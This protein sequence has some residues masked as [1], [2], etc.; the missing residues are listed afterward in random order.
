[1][2]I[3]ILQDQLRSGGTERHSLLLAREFAAAGHAASLLTFRPGGRLAG[4][5]QV[6][7]G[8]IDG[9]SHRC[10]QPFDTGL[11]WFAPGLGRAVGE[12]NP[13]IVLCMGK[14][15]NA[16]AGRLQDR[17]RREERATAVVAT[18]RSGYRLPGY[19]LRSVRR[20]PLL[21]TNSHQAADL[22]VAQY[23]LARE[24]IA[25][26][27]NALVFAGAEPGPGAVPPP[28]DARPHPLSPRPSPS[29]PTQH[30]A[31][32]P[33]SVSLSVTPA[34]DDRSESK[35][36][37]IL[38]EQLGAGPATQVMLSV[39][40]FRP[41]KNQ[42]ALIEA[43]AGLPAELDWQLW[44]AGEGPTRRECERLAQRL[45]AG[46]RVRFL[47]FTGDPAPLYRAADVA[48][49]ASREESLS[50]FLIEAQAHGLPVVAAEAL[51]NR[52]CVVPGETGW[53][54]PQDDPAAFR[55]ALLPLL[56][57]P[58]EARA[59]LAAEASAFARAAFDPERQVR[60]YLECFRELMK[61][62]RSLSG[63]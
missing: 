56:T 2:K 40:M 37:R 10:L 47:G 30:S 52:E 35:K 49:H 19:Y 59:A 61:A 21:I 43:A 17:A 34:M 31:S 9:V 23:G 24:R 26:I 58:A 60:A 15:A 13:D 46:G 63:A 57:A 48:V 53:I 29:S 5:A 44:C 4:A 16:Y 11:D 51:G 62:P 50:N 1:M 12:A 22:L 28:S 14:T 42:R 33:P 27:H 36:T 32:T 38:R 55:A 20:C 6:S 39:G 8:G 18:S 54:V 45:G 41:E 3:L 25:V 7:G